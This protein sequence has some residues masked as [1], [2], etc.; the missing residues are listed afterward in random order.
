M[1][2]FKRLNLVVLIQREEKDSQYP[3][4]GETIGVRSKRYPVPKIY[5]FTLGY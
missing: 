1:E 2:E 5:I 3:C 4:E